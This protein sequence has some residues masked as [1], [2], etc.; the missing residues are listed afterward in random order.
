MQW[1]VTLETAHLGEDAKEKNF[2]ADTYW[3]PG[4]NHHGNYGRWSFAEFTDI[5]EMQDEFEAELEARLSLICEKAVGAAP[6][7]PG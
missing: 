5:W 2:T 1:N 3:A 6:A 7:V 4:V